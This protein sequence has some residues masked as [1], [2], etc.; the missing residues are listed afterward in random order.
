M[1][2]EEDYIRKLYNYNSVL[3]IKDFIEKLVSISL[4]KIKDEMINQQI[5]YPKIFR[6]FNNN[7]KDCKLNFLKILI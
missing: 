7:H 2:T 4:K 6:N 3:F 1:I 5:Q